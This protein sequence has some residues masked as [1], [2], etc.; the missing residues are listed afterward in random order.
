MVRM[1]VDPPRSITPAH[2][3]AARALLDWTMPH[4]VKRSGLPN[5]TLRNFERGRSGIPATSLGI[6]RST[7][8]TA[9]I[10]FSDVDPEEGSSG[11]GV[12]LSGD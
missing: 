4:L 3:R 10:V 11:I 9:G 6:L 5:E 7:F 12:W 8:E 1:S 2:C